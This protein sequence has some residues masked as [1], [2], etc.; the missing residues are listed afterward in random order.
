MPEMHLKQPGLTYNAC[1]PF[2]KN[3]ERIPKFKETRDTKYICWNEL[4]KACFQHEMGYGD[5]KDLARRTGSD[6]ALRYKAFNIRKKLHKT[7]QQGFKIEKALK[8]KEINYSSNGK[9][10]ITHLIAGLI[11]KIL[12]KNESILS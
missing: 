12:Y 4:H 6:K 1:G 7:N 8:V 5:F 2:T 10:I 11:K 3:K 9:D